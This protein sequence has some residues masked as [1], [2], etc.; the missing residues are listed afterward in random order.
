MDIKPIRRRSHAQILKI[1]CIELLFYIL[2]K[3][4]VIA[5]YKFS[6]NGILWVWQ[7]TDYDAIMHFRPNK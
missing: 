4:W 1:L 7:C 6:L 3:S 5:L 2:I